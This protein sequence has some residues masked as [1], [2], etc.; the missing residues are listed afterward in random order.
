MHSNV[1]EGAWFGGNQ[2]DLTLNL[3]LSSYETLGKF[4]N[5][6]FGSTIWNTSLKILTT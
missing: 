5:S 2:G 1:V 4:P 3:L 6:E